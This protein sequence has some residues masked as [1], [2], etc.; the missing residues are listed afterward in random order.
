MKIRKIIDKRIH[1]IE[2]LKIAQLEKKLINNISNLDILIFDRNIVK[3]ILIKKLLKKFPKRCFVIKG[4]EKIKN[5]EN[6]SILI[7]RMIKLGVQRKTIIYSFGGGTLGDLSGFLAS[8]ILRGVEHVMIP[9]SLL[10]MVD[11]SI[12]G[13]T[14]INSKFGKNLI[15]T[16]YLP[17]KVFICSDFL[18]SLPKKEIACGYAEI[19]KYSLIHSKQ[20]H[21]LLTKGSNGDINKIIKLSIDS[22][23]KYISD[24]REKLKSKN[25][26]AILNFGHTI[27]H[28]IENSNLYKGNLKHGEAISLG[29]ILELKISSLLNYYPKRVDSLIEILKKYNLP[30]N[31]SKYVNKKT[32]PLLIKKIAFDKKVI[33]E[34]VNIILIGKN[35]GFIK[36]ILIRDLKSILNQIK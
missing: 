23:F 10:A 19:I 8:T 7:E 9:T 22:K 26:R 28:A 25:S 24:F 1:D 30:I 15:G 36:K 6:Y 18:K 11:S 27:G 5:L 12:G 21:K 14:G 20:L 31:Y 33:N 3:N 13:K 35:G 16:F 4:H 29:M 34:D 32:I 17:K 2:F